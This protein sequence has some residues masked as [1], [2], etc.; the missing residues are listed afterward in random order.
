MLFLYDNIQEMFHKNQ[1]FAKSNFCW[2][3]IVHTVQLSLHQIDIF[4]S[5][6]SS[7][8]ELTWLVV[9]IGY[10]TNLIQSCEFVHMHALHRP[11]TSNF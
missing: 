2:D 11:P 6:Y 8:T 9:K 10:S 1:Q 4:I 5:V 7:K 3:I